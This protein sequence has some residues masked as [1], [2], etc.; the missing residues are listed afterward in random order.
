MGPLEESVATSLR[1]D[2]TCMGGTSLQR[3]RLRQHGHR[4]ISLVV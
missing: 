3:L 1:P 4:E 2:R